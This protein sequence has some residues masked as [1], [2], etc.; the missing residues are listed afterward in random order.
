MKSLLLT[1][2][3]K[4]IVLKRGSDS[5]YALQP[6]RGLYN[7]R[8]TKYSALDQIDKDLK[9]VSGFIDRQG[10]RWYN[11]VE[12]GVYMFPFNSFVYY[13]N[14]TAAVL[15]ESRTISIADFN[16]KIYFGFENKGMGYLSENRFRNLK[17]PVNKLE[18]TRILKLVKAGRF[19]LAGGDHVLIRITENNRIEV[20]K[21]EKKMA[22]KDID[23]K[24]TA[25]LL[26]FHAGV[27]RSN[28]L[29]KHFDLIFSERSTAVHNLKDGSILIGTLRGVYRFFEGHTKKLN[30]DPVVD[31]TRISDIKQDENGRIWISS[32]NQ[33]LFITDLNTT[34]S[35]TEFNVKSSTNFITSNIC[36]E[37][38]MYRNEV[39]LSTSKGINRIKLVNFEKQLFEI[40]RFN[41]ASGLPFED[42]NELVILGDTVWAV[43]SLGLV[44]F[45]YK[46]IKP[47]LPPAIVLDK[48]LVNLR[49]TS[50]TGSAIFE[51]SQNNISFVFTG[52]SINGGSDITYK[53]RLKGLA[54]SWNYIS[55]EKID[56]LGL[57]PGSYELEVYAINSNFSESPHPLRFSFTIVPP[58]YQTWW[59]TTII[60]LLAAIIAFSALK[61]KIK[62]TREKEKIKTQIADLKLKALRAQMNPHFIFNVLTSIQ[63]FF[64]KNDELTANKYMSSFSELIRQILNSSR[65]DF[66]T[67]SEELDILNKYISLEILRLEK[68]TNYSINIGADVKTEEIFVPSMLLQPLVENALLHGIRFTTDEC[69]NLTIDVSTSNNR[70]EI[71][72]SDNGKG[73][74]KSAFSKQSAGLEITRQRIDTINHLYGIDIKLNI[75]DIS[76]LD[77]KRHGTQ[78]EFSSMIYNPTYN[79]IYNA[80]G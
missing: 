45:N 31:D 16:N 21:S 62:S 38:C 67:L 57:P 63:Y 29:L 77:I 70:L 33:G 40:T 46:N 5:I 44:K 50:V 36:K 19:L 39:W 12:S 75:A 15:N 22:I 56:F 23:V 27:A 49:D 78:V 10:N 30:L 3:F 32:Y 48:I 51:S 71:R 54:D 53:Y 79:E 68:R 55:S 42:V 58:I 76:D 6:S 73:I 4:N 8:E 80:L 37:L 59:F 25:V 2:P 52:I 41:G 34:I 18:R 61:H 17:L 72:I 60:I 74:K 47:V 7:L 9:F 69:G 64:A 65:R 11:T 14:S 20:P 24:D 43:S 35:L 13:D 28:I 66:N 26:A 1:V